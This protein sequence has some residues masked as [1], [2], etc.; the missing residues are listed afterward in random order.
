MALSENARQVIAQTIARTAY[1]IPVSFP[2]GGIDTVM[3]ALERELEEAGLVVVRR[4][5]LKA[6][7]WNEIQDSRDADV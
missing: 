2:E 5:D 6:I 3:A 1:A 4:D 7:G